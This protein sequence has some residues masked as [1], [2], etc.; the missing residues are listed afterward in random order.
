MDELWSLNC[1]YAN[2]GIL[3]R[4]G[5]IVCGGAPIFNKLIGEQLSLLP[6]RYQAMFISEWNQPWLQKD[7]A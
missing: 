3:V 5:M 7:S 6:S 2:G 1:S 4:D